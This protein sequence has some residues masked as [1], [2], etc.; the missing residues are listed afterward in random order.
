MN[1]GQAKIRSDS[2][3]WTELYVAG[4]KSG[5]FKSRKELRSWKLF[6]YLFPSKVPENYV[7]FLKYQLFIIF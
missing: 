4:K 1:C 5:I 6:L 7:N 2:L 3:I